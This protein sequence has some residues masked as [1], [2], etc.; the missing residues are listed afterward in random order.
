MPQGLRF[1]NFPA[2]AHYIELLLLQTAE[3]DVKFCES[4][5][6]KVFR[7]YYYNTLV[8][9]LEQI[10]HSGRQGYNS[11]LSNIEAHRQGFIIA[12]DFIGWGIHI[13]MGLYRFHWLR[14]TDSE[15]LV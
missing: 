8:T 13:R 1:L 11:A 3:H 6:A 14:Y 2:T 4:N 15:G 7:I 9:R 10:M 5:R 12:I